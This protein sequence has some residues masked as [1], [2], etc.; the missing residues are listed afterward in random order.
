MF[1]TDLFTLDRKINWQLIFM[2]ELL[3][4]ATPWIFIGIFYLNA[5]I[6]TYIFL[7]LGLILMWRSNRVKK[8][9]YK[10]STNEVVF[11]TSDSFILMISVVL[12]IITFA[13]CI[14]VKFFMV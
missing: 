11:E 13:Y 5:N 1:S 3:R 6:F 7:I 14:F 9:V 8:I 10:E 4:N 12:S 2:K